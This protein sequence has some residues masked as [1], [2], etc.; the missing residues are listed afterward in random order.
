MEKVEIKAIGVLVMVMILLSFTHAELNSK[1]DAFLCN[2]KCSLMCNSLASPEYEKCMI[3]CESNCEK[4]SSDPIFKC[5]TSCDL[6]K[7]IAYN[8]GMCS[9]KIFTCFNSF[10]FL[11]RFHFIKFFFITLLIS[12]SIAYNFNH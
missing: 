3:K 5:F 6:M 12:F 7:V 4:I 11:F 1:T 10:T 9:L 2:V 8:T